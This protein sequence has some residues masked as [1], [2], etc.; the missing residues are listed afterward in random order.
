MIFFKLKK[1]AWRVLFFSVLSI[2]VFTVQAATITI[3]NIDS[4]G[5]GFN[6]PTDVT[7]VTGN[8][9][10]TLG[11]QRLTV[12]QAAAD[13]WGAVLTSSVT[14][15]IEMQFNPLFCD[16]S[17][18]T[19]GQAGPKSGHRDFTG[20]PLAGTWYP[21][22]LA[23][24]LRGLD[25]GSVDPPEDPVDITSTF[26][27]DID[28][29]NACLNDTDWW[30]GINSPAPSGT[31]DFYGVLLHEI[32]HGLGFTTF[33]DTT[34]TGA[35][36]NGYPDTYE[37]HLEDH[38]LGLNWPAMDN[39]QRLASS[40]DTG[41]LH[42]TGTHVINNTSGLSAGVG[43]S[44]HVQMYAP[45]PIQPGSSVAHWDTAVTPNEL[46]EPFKTAD[47]AD[48][49]TYNLLKD[50]G[51][52]VSGSVTGAPLIPI[53]SSPIDGS[54]LSGTSQ[55]FD[56]TYSGVDDSNW[57]IYLGSSV[58]A[59]NYYYSGVLAA[60]T[61][62]HTVT[63]IPT[64]G[65]TVYFR[66]WRKI[67]GVWNYTDGT[68]TA[69]S[70]IQPIITN[71][72][73][74]S[75]LSG[76]SQLFNWTYGGVDDSNWTIYLG[77]SVGAYNYYYSGVLTAATRSHTV[78]GIP[79]NGAT[80][81]FRLWRKISGVWNYTDGTYTASSGAGGVQPIITNPVDGSTLSGTSQLF[82]WTYGEVDDSNWTIYLGSSVGAYNYYYSGVLAAATRSHTV[83]GIPTNGST[84]YFR[85][86]R[87]VSGVWNYTDGTYTASSG[88][89]GVQPIITS[90][91]D[92]STLSGS[93]QLFNWTYGEVDDSNWTIYLGSSVGAYNYYYSGVLAA[94][95]RSHTVIG[96]PTNGSTVYFRLWRKVS[97][98]WNYTDGTYTASSGAGGVQPIITSPVDG[99][100]LSGT[101]Q[102]FN[103]TYGEVD[104]S[105]WTIYLGS[106]V[107]AYNYY[108]SGVLAAGTRSH[109]VTGIPTNG[110]T[111]YFRL[112]RK[113]SGVWSY[114]DATYTAL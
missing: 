38:S 14:I 93:S 35:E 69:S 23:D 82:N 113:I 27:S 97:G 48:L 17:S 68:Y 83:T 74:G 105:N 73:D 39:A 104:D 33:V 61:R 50:I 67:S 106:S 60:A 80:V 42:W 81:Y 109:T 87:K 54:T 95:T 13:A 7:A 45:N 99:S 56:W 77:S 3:S 64:N 55:V 41:D 90:P 11:G 72:V 30:Y 89:G 103:W 100:T 66:L 2:F 86:W 1:Q 22:A 114:T 4:A 85:L 111:V 6:D 31:I 8:A 46:M 79:T 20:A 16:A 28:Q 10:T 65:S 44:N 32:G 71:P 110:S 9:A 98:V 25:L 53:I 78:T 5:E 88:A 108:Y 18:A 37:V 36:A 94:G 52:T 47:A 57:T 101:S 26:N 91:V 62:S 70:G 21:S 112:W 75:T 29:N 76:T 59:Y 58:G 40:T 92:G 15:I 43:A 102:L 63:G 96:I 84:V 19:L 107:G 12:A 51:W 49:I 34:T 24:S